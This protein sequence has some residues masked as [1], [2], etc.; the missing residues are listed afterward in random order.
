MG[1]LVDHWTLSLKNVLFVGSAT[2]CYPLASMSS[3]LTFS[4]YSEQ[5]LHCQCST[6]HGPY[7]EI[8]GYKGRCKHVKD[9]RGKQ[10]ESFDQCHGPA[11]AVRCSLGMSTLQ[12][13]DI[14]LYDVSP[15]PFSW[16]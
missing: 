3:V 7:C 12:L 15:T 4:Y 8:N 6:D 9:C 16:S 13:F 10:V 5:A 1:Q 2:I 11:A 14:R